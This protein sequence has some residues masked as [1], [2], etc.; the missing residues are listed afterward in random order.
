MEYENTV[1]LSE[2]TTL[3][4]PQELS[5]YVRRAQEEYG[6]I[7]E[8]DPAMTRV[9]EDIAIFSRM[10]IIMTILGEPGVG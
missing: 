4:E 6:Y 9:I 3:L 7:V 1:G 8:G 5:A 10:N 2:Q